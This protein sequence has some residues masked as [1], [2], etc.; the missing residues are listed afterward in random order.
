MKITYEPGDIVSIEDNKNAGAIVATE[1]RLIRKISPTK[2]WWEV[3]VFEDDILAGYTQGE[4]GTIDEKWFR[5]VY[6]R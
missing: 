5:P 6:F 1:V 4:K 3:E 2:S